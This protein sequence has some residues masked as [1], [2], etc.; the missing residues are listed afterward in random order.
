MIIVLYILISGFLEKRR[1]DKASRT[2]RQPPLHWA[3][4]FH[5]TS[6]R[7]RSKSRLC[8]DDCRLSGD[9]FSQ[10]A[11]LCYVRYTK[12]GKNVERRSR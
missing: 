6:Q 1:E 11:S 7:W 9:R 10:S 8:I 3:T 5:L 4:L 2:E 12:E